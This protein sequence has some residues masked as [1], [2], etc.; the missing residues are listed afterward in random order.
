MGGGKPLEE[1]KPRVRVTLYLD[2]D[3][4]KM[5]KTLSKKTRV[6]WSEYVREGVDMVLKKYKKHLKR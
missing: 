3:Q 1:N 4:K 2:A 5:L 6:V